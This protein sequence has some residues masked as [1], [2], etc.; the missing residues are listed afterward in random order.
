MCA[1]FNIYTDLKKI[2]KKLKE[3]NIDVKIDEAIK[4]ADINNNVRLTNDSPVM[5][6]EEDKPLLTLMNWGIKFSEKSPIIFNS[7]IETIKKEKRWQT[8]FERSRC[9]IPMTSFIEYRKPEDDPPDVKKWK[10]ENKIKR[11]TP[12]HI[13][14]PDEPFFFAPGI[15]INLQG[16]NFYS[17]ITTEPPPAVRQI[18]YKR[19][20]ALLKYDEAVDYLY[21]EMNHSMDMIQP[22]N[23]ELKVEEGEIKVNA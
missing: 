14:I 1:F 6:K 12:F 17:I 10:K 22:Y 16:Q 19:S 18:P 8:I 13:S 15:F 7:R 23:G 5:V 4:D 2:K 3:K 20:L 11:N 21:N 9:L